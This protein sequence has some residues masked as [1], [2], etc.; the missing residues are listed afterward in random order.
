MKKI[1]LKVYFKKRKQRL[2]FF[3][4]SPSFDWLF[5]LAFAALLLISGIVYAVYLYI[6]VNNGSLF[7]TIED[8]TVQTEFE[9][10]KKRIQQKVELLKQR[11]F[12]EKAVN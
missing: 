10:K 4:A 11:D 7:E 2:S 5:I 8:T 1:N 12:D 6:Q 9:S 3:G